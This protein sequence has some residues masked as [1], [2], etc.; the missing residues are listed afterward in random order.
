MFRSRNGS[1][2]K[3]GFHVGPK[4]HLPGMK[5]AAVIVHGFVSC[6]FNPFFSD[7]I[8]EKIVPFQRQLYTV[9]RISYL[10]GIILI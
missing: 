10:G 1:T 6:C 5:Y 4:S 9:C 7:V 8:E 2:T 3:H